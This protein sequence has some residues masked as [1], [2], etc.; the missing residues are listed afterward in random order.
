MVINV[1]ITRKSAKSQ[2][3]KERHDVYLLIM[4]RY[5]LHDLC[6]FS[7]MVINVDVLIKSGKIRKKYRDRCRSFSTML[8]HCLHVSVAE[9]SA[10]AHFGSSW[11]S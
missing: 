11:L 6:T 10:L 2:E 9:R 7:N 4:L 5:S 3:K 8:V 1:K